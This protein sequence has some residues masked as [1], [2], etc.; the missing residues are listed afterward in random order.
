[1]PAPKKVSIQEDRATTDMADNPFKDQGK[2]TYTDEEISSWRPKFIQAE[3]V[4]DKQKRRPDDPLYDKSS[5]YIPP[6][7][8]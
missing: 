7:E 3:Y 6:Y 8:F 2:Y 4:M 1:M 5:L